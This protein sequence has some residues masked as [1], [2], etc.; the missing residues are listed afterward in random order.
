MKPT[1]LYLLLATAFSQLTGCVQST[2]E[3]PLP[4]GGVEKSSSWGLTD[5]AAEAASAGMRH[6]LRMPVE[7]R[8]EK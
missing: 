1:L 7:P 5:R 3:R 2:I 8:A 6:Y 4:G